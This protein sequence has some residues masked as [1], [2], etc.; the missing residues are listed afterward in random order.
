M[1]IKTILFCICFALA[2]LWSSF[3]QS[4]SDLVCINHALLVLDSTTYDAV[5]NSEFINRFAYSQ[6]KQRSGYQGFYLFGKTNYIELFHPNSIEGEVNDP[7]TIWM[8]FAALQANYLEKLNTEKLDC[9]ELEADDYFKRLVLLIHDSINPMDT[10]EMTKTHYEGWT[11]KEYNDSVRFLPVDY[12]SPQE[13]DSSS[14]YLMSDI[15][16][17]GLTLNPEDSLTV[18][19]YLETIGFNDASVF[20]GHSRLSNGDQF[21]ELRTAVDI[22]SPTINRFYIRLNQSIEQSTEIIGNS[23]LECTGKSAVWIFEE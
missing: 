16:G 4:R 5:I 19:R 8:C 18:T 9:I 2:N 13:S 15:C 21:V 22:D 1:N 3:G 14:N 12:N 23:R 11:K 20:N 17:I 6:E 7:G 10:W